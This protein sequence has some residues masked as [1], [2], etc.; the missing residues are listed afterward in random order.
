MSDILNRLKSGIKNYREMVWPGTDI[1][2]RLRVLS[3]SDYQ[4]AYMAADK[5]Y[6]DNKVDL[7]LANVDE[8]AH[9]VACRVLHTAVCDSDGKPLIKEF[10]DFHAVLTADV[11]DVLIEELNA[12]QELNSPRINGMSDEEMSTLL[13]SVKKNPEIALSISSI[14]S[15]RKL[16]HTLALPP[17]MPLTDK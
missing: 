6:R 8:R 1:A 9:Y 2:I 15:L 12:H 3:E 11:R 14:S 13:E 16:V 4:A 7:N 10:A 5:Y 17:V